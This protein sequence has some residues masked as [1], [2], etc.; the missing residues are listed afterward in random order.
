MID[1][2]PLMASTKI[3]TG[4]RSGPPISFRKT[5]HSEAERHRDHDRRG[6]P[7]RACRRWRAQRRPSWPVDSG[8]RELLRLREE[9]PR[10]RV[11][12]LD[13]DVAE[14]QRRAARPSGQRGRRDDHRHRPVAGHHVGRRA[15]GRPAS[16]CTRKATYQQISEPDR[17]P[18][19]ARAGRASQTSENDDSAAAG[20]DAGVASVPNDRGR[21]GR[22]VS[23]GSG[24]GPS[25][26]VVAAR[27]ARWPSDL[28]PR[29]GARPA[30]D[31]RGARC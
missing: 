29:A 17:R 26:A 14:D 1:G 25:P 19:A 30:H 7:A 18:R 20:Q 22:S 12:A 23:A 9:V 16:R 2:T 4:R 8:P 10:Q 21:R 11:D 31:D 3:R 24:A 13:E 27:G 28:H 6:R 15:R 5:A